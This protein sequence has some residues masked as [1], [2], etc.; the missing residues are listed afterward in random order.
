MNQLSDKPEHVGV[1]NKP[2]SEQDKIDLNHEIS[3]VPTGRRQRFLTQND[4]DIYG[5][6]SEKQ[7]SERRY[8]SMLEMLLAED[9]HY[10][11]LY[12]KVQTQLYDARR[13]LI[14]ALSDITQSLEAFER[15]LQGIKNRATE[16]RDG[17]KVFQ[18]AIDGAVYTENGERLSDDEA[19]KIRFS[20][21]APSWEEF[22]E[23]KN[24]VKTVKEQK[25]EIEVY[26]RDID[27]SEKRLHDKDNPLTVDELKDLQK[28]IEK[29]MSEKTVEA[30]SQYTS[31]N[32][33][34]VMQSPSV[35]QDVQGKIDLSVPDVSAAFDKARYEIPDL[36]R[37]VPTHQPSNTLS[38]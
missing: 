31:P 23:A 26:K 3:S 12:N 16:N 13:A 30:H 37:S 17:V 34:A 38:T 28:D 22:K 21:N 6:E 11:A 10:A 29:I 27:R 33:Q 35:A 2:K 9:A 4:Y 25:T 36:I 8:H 15:M 14:K 24:K 20:A 32:V 1:D 19:R 7:K 18:S 5:K